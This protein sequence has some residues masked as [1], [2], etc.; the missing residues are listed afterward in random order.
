MIL[1]AAFL[2]GCGTL[3]V[4]VLGVHRLAP[5]FGASTLVWTN[6]IGVILFAMAVGAGLGGSLSRRVSQPLVSAGRLLLAAGVLLA[7]GTWLLP[8]FARWLLPSGLRLQDAASVFLGGSLAAGLLFFAP[9]VLLLA[10][11]APLLVH[12]RAEE[13][14]AGRAAGE[15]SAA[16]TAGSLLGVFGTS[17]IALPTLGARTTLFLMA[18]VLACAGLLL[19]RR[20]GWAPLAASVFL[21]NL[22]ADPSV[23]AH[24]PPG[25][26]LLVSQESALQQVRIL[27][28]DD[29]SRWLQ[30]N[31][32]MDSYQSVWASQGGWAGGYYDWF[33]WA[34]ASLDPPSSNPVPLQI[35]SLGAGTG[36]AFTVLAAALDRP[37]NGVGVELDP[38][39][40]ALGAQWMPLSLPPGQVRMIA[41]DA[42]ACLRAAPKP[43]DLVL[44]DAYSRQF[45]LPLHLVTR[46]FFQEISEHLVDGGILALNLGPTGAGDAAALRNPLWVGLQETFADVRGYSVPFARNTMLMARKN[47]AFPAA[48]DVLARLPDNAPSVFAAAPFCAWAPPDLTGVDSFSDD[49]P[50]LILAHLREWR[51]GGE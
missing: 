21:L 33:G 31:E 3:A 43:L 36:T 20:K 46:E 45:E 5:W 27:S 24:L 8:E 49:K 30:V 26:R 12:A 32:G 9:P 50:R 51:G 7:I 13:R 41:G 42:R 40:L 11:V 48:M 25:S 38:V 22:P 14:G 6:Q 29:R 44:L 16:G 23:Q 28:F 35:W 37:W 39:V 2:A 4:E 47:R 15:I 1:L 19:L 17:F 10:M 34:A 18:A